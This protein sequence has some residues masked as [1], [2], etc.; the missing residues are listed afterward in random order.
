MVID[1]QFLLVF[2]T[3]MHA[4]TNHYHD[5]A[6]SEAHLG[7]VQALYIS[8]RNTALDRALLFIYSIR[9]VTDSSIR[10]FRVS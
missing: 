9:A 3:I 4:S 10:V 7:K 5:V 2:A 6:V 1:N 8:K